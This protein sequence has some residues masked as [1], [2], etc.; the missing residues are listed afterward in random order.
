MKQ[1][2]SE[3]FALQRFQQKQLAL[4][5]W[6]KLLASNISASTFGQRVLEK[7]DRDSVNAC[8]MEILD[9]IFAVK[10]PK[11]PYENLLRLERV[12]RLL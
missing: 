5:S 10:S 11:Y 12:L 3:D 6:W 8:A 7:A 1:T 4:R 2:D 9:A